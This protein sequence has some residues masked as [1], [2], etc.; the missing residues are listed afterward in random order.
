MDV[1]LQESFP[2]KESLHSFHSVE[3]NVCN[4]FNSACFVRKAKNAQDDGDGQVGLD[5]GC[6]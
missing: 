2:R 5:I 6:P 4:A 3:E 1:A